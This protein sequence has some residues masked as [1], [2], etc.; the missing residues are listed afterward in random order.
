VQGEY[1]RNDEERRQHERPGHH[2]GG[3]GVEA[4]VPADRTRNSGAVA[5]SG[6]RIANASHSCFVDVSP[7]TATAAATSAQRATTAA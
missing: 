3:C 5:A 6:R 7:A 4:V 1:E 2:E